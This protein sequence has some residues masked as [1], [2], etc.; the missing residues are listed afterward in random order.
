MAIDSEAYLTP[1]HGGD[2][3]WGIIQAFKNKT[4]YSKVSTLT[5]YEYS[6]S[7]DYQNNGS[8]EVIACINGHTHRDLSATQDGILLI[9]TTASGF[10]QTAYDSTGTQII[11]TLDTQTETAFDIFSFDRK[12]ET[13]TASRYGAGQNRNWSY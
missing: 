10:S 2:A 11:Y 8:N 4:A 1:T 7:V 3:L 9:S 12:N 6:V 13:I 5:N